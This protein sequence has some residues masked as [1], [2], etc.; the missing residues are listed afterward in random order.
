MMLCV[1]N[2]VFSAEFETLS[3]QPI[4]WEKRFSGAC[5]H[6]LTG[7]IAPGDA[8]KVAAE[9][10]SLPGQDHDDLNF[11]VC[12]NSP[13]G[14]L[15]D[16]IAIGKLFKDN[17]FGTFVPQG[18]ECL[19]ACAVAFMH[20]TVGAYEYF[21]NHRMM[22]PSARVGFHAPSL[23]F[24]GD[25][26]D[27]VPLSLVNAAYL[28]ARK[29]IAD[30]VA[31][32]SNPVSDFAAP[33]I[34]L[35]LLSGMLSTPENDFLYVDTLHQAFAWQID[36]YP[37]NLKAPSGFHIEFGLYQLCENASYKIDG[38]NTLFSGRTI[39]AEEVKYNRV[40]Y[41]WNVDMPSDHTLLSLGNIFNRQ[42]SYKYRTDIDGFE[43][44]RYVDGDLEQE[45]WLPSVYLLSPEVR[46]IELVQ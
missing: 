13:G 26:N 31:A 15:A 43:L 10:A 32:A 37:H 39:T 28:A 22:H 40:T 33:V 30:I 9:I 4:A 1:G 46:L 23:P 24:E 5:T 19:S 44:R 45:V 16:G 2:P 18:A 17:F 25:P 35:Q 6:R 21:L 42:C 3:T 20:G 29:N 7:E 27:L 41:P 38:G 11:I 12:M 8:G 36:I 14:S 34:P